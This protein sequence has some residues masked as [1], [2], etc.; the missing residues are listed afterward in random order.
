MKKLAKKLLHSG[1]PVPGF[2][3]PIGRLKYHL[4]V[5]IAEGLRALYAWFIVKPIM[6]C[7]AEVGDGLMIE[8][9]PYIRGKG[10]IAIGAS[11]YVSGKL[12]VSFSSHAEQLPELR[13][14]DNAFIGHQC[15]FSMAR[16][17]TIGDNC[18]IGA[19][20]RIQDNDGHPMDPERRRAREPVRPEDVKPVTIGNNVW[21][22]PRATVL[23][24]VTIGDNAV[25]GTGSVVTKDVA[26]N[27]VVA[28]IP[29]KV[30]KELRTE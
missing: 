11:V 18:L 28:G 10:N 12:G 3:K 6:K 5:A 17:I 25:V 8:R 22:A 26:A 7:I 15:S 20:V 30:I 1:L 29:A 2:L 4:G 13:I 21:I 27:T 16:Q 23:K 24:G 14:G 19:G 9:V